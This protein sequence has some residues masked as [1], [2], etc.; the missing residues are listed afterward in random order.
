MSEPQPIRR[1]SKG[2]RGRGEWGPLAVM[3]LLRSDLMDRTDG[4][5]AAVTPPPPPGKPQAHVRCLSARTL[6]LFPS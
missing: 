2:P 5:R 4:S 6:V 1:R 3:A